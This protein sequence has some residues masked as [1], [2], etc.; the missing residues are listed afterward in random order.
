MDA[1]L[2]SLFVLSIHV[3]LKF[4]F[5][6]CHIGRY[7]LVRRRRTSMSL[8][9]REVAFPCFEDRTAQRARHQ[10]QSLRAG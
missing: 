8:Q 6:L 4:G 10:F 7:L 3:V 5:R 1:I 9:D 2:I